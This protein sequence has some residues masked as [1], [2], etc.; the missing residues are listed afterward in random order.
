M[1]GR[2]T[3]EEAE[4]IRQ[5]GIFFARATKS[6]KAIQNVLISCYGMSRSRYSGVIHREVKL[7]DLFKE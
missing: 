5:R 7:D 1:I 2:K 3:A 4:K 6:R